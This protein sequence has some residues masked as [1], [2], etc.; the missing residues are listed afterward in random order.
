MDPITAVVGGTLATA[1]AAYYYLLG[2]SQHTDDPS[3]PKYTISNATTKIDDSV[4]N[5]GFV[6]VDSVDK[7]IQNDPDAKRVL[8]VLLENGGEQFSEE[9]KK[10]VLEDVQKVQKKKKCLIH[11]LHQNLL[12]PL[13]PVAS[14]RSRSKDVNNQ[15][16]NIIDTML[17]MALNNR[18]KSMEKQE[19][20]E[21]VDFE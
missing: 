13:K 18:R 5:M 21:D 12:C 4:E 15:S 6:S 3:G 9:K 10:K 16:Q 14:P 19:D 17:R 7:D 2:P 8:E 11:D 20:D 1:Y